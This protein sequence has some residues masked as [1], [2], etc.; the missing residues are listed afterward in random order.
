MAA[1]FVLVTVGGP[2][3]LALVCAVIWGRNRKRLYL[4][5]AA[6]LVLAIGVVLYA[7]FSAPPDA[8]HDSIG[9]S[10]CEQFLGRWWEPGFVAFVVVIGYVTWLAGVGCGLGMRAF[11]WRAWR[12]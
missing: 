8:Q 2:F 5:L 1:V 6:G 3:V 7:Y 12:S 10:D 9:C 4:L 11:G